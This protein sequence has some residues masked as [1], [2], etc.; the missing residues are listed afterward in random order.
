MFFSFRDGDPCLSER[1]AHFVHFLCHFS[2]RVGIR[3]SLSAYHRHHQ[4]C[5]GAG[6]GRI[7]FKTI[8][9]SYFGNIA[10]TFYATRNTSIFLEN[11]SLRILSIFYESISDEFYLSK[12]T[13]F[14]KTRRLF[15]RF[16]KW[17]L[18]HNSNAIECVFSPQLFCKVI[19]L[20]YFYVWVTVIYF[21]GIL[22]KE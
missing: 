7:F 3:P 17:Q 21:D 18:V 1:S 6:I 15:Y 14:K 11:N 19:P 10:D 2:W 8:S 9:I 16:L 5:H 12:M 4:N 22:C 20:W 13:T